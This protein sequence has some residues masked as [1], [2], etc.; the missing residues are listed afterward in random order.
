MR[1][2][3]AVH[4]GPEYRISE[5][6]FFRHDAGAQ[7]LALVIS[8]VQIGVQRFHALLKAARELL[9]FA[10]I[11]NARN[12]VEGDQALGGSGFAIDRK[13][14]ADAAE[15][16]L[17]FLATIVE[18]VFRDVVQPVRELLIGRPDRAVR[19]THLVEKRRT[20]RG[21]ILLRCSACDHASQRRLA[22]K[23]AAHML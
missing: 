12:D 20:T 17:G 3:L 9:P 18:D 16:E 14:D 19:R 15:D 23:A 21:Q 13:R 10:A 1:H 8:V 22:Q 4:L 11:E 7:N 5:D 6:E 2:R